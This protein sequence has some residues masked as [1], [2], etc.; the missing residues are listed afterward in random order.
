[1]PYEMHAARQVSSNDDTPRPLLHLVAPPIE[2]RTDRAQR[3]IALVSIA[4]VAIGI[5]LVGVGI[6]GDAWG[7][8]QSRPFLTNIL[9]T[10]V[11]ACFGLPLAI[12][13]LRRVIELRDQ[14]AGQQ[15]DVAESEAL[16][17]S[18]KASARRIERTLPDRGDGARLSD[19][20]WEAL[21]DDIL[22]LVDVLARNRAIG[23][24][25]VADTVRPLTER[26]RRAG[27]GHVHVAVS[28][29]RQDWG[30]LCALPGMATRVRGW[31]DEWAGTRIIDVRTF[32]DILAAFD[33][34]GSDVWC[35]FF[36]RTPT[37]RILGENVL[38]DLRTST[39]YA[40]RF[41]HDTGTILLRLQGAD[42]L[43]AHWHA[44]RA[45]HNKALAHQY[46]DL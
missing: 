18:M 10:M 14:E 46:Q 13:V 32:D 43:R 28:E 36:A 11:G 27:L 7:W 2:A 34:P 5:V 37:D 9:S 16:I 23:S 3:L 21:I 15:R 19:S 8:W 26:F 42:V 45:A 44:A 38:P 6:L 25:E 4:L 40:L 35:D 39:Q 33:E 20:D 12:V 29:I 31:E 22:V 24:G 17:E 41:L 1:M 30:R